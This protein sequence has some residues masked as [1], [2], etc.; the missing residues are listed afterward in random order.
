MRSAHKEV[1]FPENI[2]HIDSIADEIEEKFN[3]LTI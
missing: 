3:L 2:E 1:E